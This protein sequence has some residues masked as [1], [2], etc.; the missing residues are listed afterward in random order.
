LL[1]DGYIQFRPATERKDFCSIQPR[2]RRISRAFAITEKLLDQKE[3]GATMRS[4]ANKKVISAVS[5]P[6]CWPR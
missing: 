4:S 6:F 3:D 5:C 2:A 1:L